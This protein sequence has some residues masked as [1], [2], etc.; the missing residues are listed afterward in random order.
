VVIRDG[1]VDAAAT[2]TLRTSRR[3][4]GPRPHFAYGPERDAHEAIWTD[5]AYDQLTRL[6][7]AL[8]VHWRFFVKTK[9]FEAMGAERQDVPLVFA[10]VRQAYPEIPEVTP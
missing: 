1:A 8:P 6:L 4:T 7:A 10:I 9:M 2:E 3:G 5:D